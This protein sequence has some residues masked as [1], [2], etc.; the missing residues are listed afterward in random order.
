[1]GSKYPA[2]SPEPTPNTNTQKSLRRWDFTS[3]FSGELPGGPPTPGSQRPGPQVHSHNTSADRETQRP[4]DR[5]PRPRAWGPGECGPRPPSQGRPAHQPLPTPSTLASPVGPAQ[6][7]GVKLSHGASSQP[8]PEPTR[9]LRNASSLRREASVGKARAGGFWGPGGSDE[10]V[11]EQ[12][13]LQAPQNK[14]R[15]LDSQG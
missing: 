6:V 10:G 3:S 1:M 5:C 13:Q 15:E 12:Q 9:L 7:L 8:S 11:W 2:R 4:A 14:A